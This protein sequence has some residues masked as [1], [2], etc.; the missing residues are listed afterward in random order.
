MQSEWREAA[1]TTVCIRES[2]ARYKTETRRDA[3]C[4]GVH[5]GKNQLSTVASLGRGQTAP[6]DTIRD[7]TPERTKRCRK[8][9]VWELLSCDDTTAKKGHHFVA[10]TK[11]VASF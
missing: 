10:M 11:K 5:L 1:K 6:G 8:M 4:Q 9:G 2:A 3:V 7:V